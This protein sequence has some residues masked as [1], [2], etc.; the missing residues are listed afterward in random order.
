MPPSSF[1]AT[2]EVYLEG[3]NDDE[4]ED[5]ENDTVYNDSDKTRSLAYSESLL[6]FSEKK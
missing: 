3:S 6:E 1:F 4:N 5:D 2:S